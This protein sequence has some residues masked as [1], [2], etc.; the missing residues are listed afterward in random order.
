MLP[1]CAISEVDIPDPMCPVTQ[2]SDWSPCS[3]TCGRG[4]TIRKR[5]LLAL[6]ENREECTKRMVLDQQQECTGQKVDCDINQEEAQRKTFVKHF[7][8]GTGRNCS[9]FS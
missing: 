2:W 1:E 9:L 5:L 3:K 7:I 6:E 4:V 8:A